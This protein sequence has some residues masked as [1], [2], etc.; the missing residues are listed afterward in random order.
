LGKD[1]AQNPLT[2]RHL[3]YF[4]KLQK[5]CMLA[6]HMI[7]FSLQILVT[8]LAFADSTHAQTPPP[9]T[10]HRLQ[11]PNSDNLRRTK[12]KAQPKKL[13]LIP[14]NSFVM[15]QKSILMPQNLF[16]M[17]QNL[18]LNSKLKPRDKG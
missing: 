10:V 7:T 8:N 9:S 15:S 6:K 18:I 12:K 17:L 5:I 13:I 2:I 3:T 1:S 16:L 4:K 11:P 14:K